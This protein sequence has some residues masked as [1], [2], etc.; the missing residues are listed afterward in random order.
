MK[1]QLLGQ[2]DVI[3]NGVTRPLGGPRQRAVLAALLLHANEEVRTTRLLELVWSDLPSSARSNLRTYLARLRRALRIPGEPE[4]RLQTRRCGHLVTVGPGE[5]DVATFL[6]FASLGERATDTVTAC[7][8]Y[9]R[10]LNA[11]RGRALE[12]VALGPL[13]EAEATQ[14]EAQRERVYERYLQVRLALGQ[15]AELLP[16]LRAQLLRNPLWEHLASMLMVALDRSGQRAEALNVFR[17]TRQRLVEEL[18]VEPG[19]EL[20]D[21][22]Q[23]LLADDDLAAVTERLAIAI[24]SAD[25][26]T[27]AVEKPTRATAK[28][29]LRRIRLR[30]RAETTDPVPPTPTDGE[31]STGP[32]QLPVDVPTFTGRAA[33]LAELAELTDGERR[34]S[35]PIIA[36]DGMAGVGKTTLAVHTAHL[37]APRFTDGQLFVNLHGCSS[38]DRPLD[39]DDVLDQML[40][41]F[42]VYTSPSTTTDLRASLF[43]SLLARRKIIVVLDN[44]FDEAQV[45]PLLPGAGS[46]QALVTSRRR[47]AGLHE[48]YSLSL[49]VLSSTDAVDLF[50]SICTAQRLA[51]QPL[52]LVEEI[53]ELCGL[54]PLAIRIAAMRL[55]IRPFWTLRDLRDRL[56]DEQQRLTELRAGE[57]DVESTVSLSLTGLDPLGQRVITMLGT[58]PGTRIELNAAAALAGLD[59]PAT[60]RVLE[61]LVDTHLLRQTGPTRYQMHSLVRATMIQR[62]RGEQPDEVDDAVR[63]LL[64]YY[65]HTADAADRQLQSMRDRPALCPADPAV[66]PLTFA[67]AEDALA[68]CDQFNPDFL[69]L[70]RAAVT[71][72]LFEHAWQLVVRMESY[73]DIRENWVGGMAVYELAL[74][75]A[76]QQAR[77]SVESELL[78]GLA[79][80][81][82]QLG[83]YDQAIAHYTTA[84]AVC[85]ETGSEYAEAFAA[86]ALARICR[87]L[88]RDGQAIGH[89]RR[90]LEIYRRLNDIP[91]VCVVLDDLG[92]TY[93][94]KGSLADAI[95]CYQEAFR[96]R[97]RVG[98]IQG[99]GR[100]LLKVGEA[101]CRAGHYAEA[102]KAARWAL[103]LCAQAGELDSESRT[104]L[105]QDVPAT[106]GLV[107]AHAYLARA[108]LMTDQ[109]AGGQTDDLA[110][111]LHLLDR[112]PVDQQ[113]PAAV[114]AQRA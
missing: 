75:A 13:L 90:A 66:T 9:E 53:V 26:A 58:H 82:A 74:Q 101:N 56:T 102:I 84:L 37:L 33:E 31:G 88:H 108:R 70:T 2:V 11:W 61:Q 68:W 86:M 15:H 17:Q 47:L 106:V 30:H 67:S 85:R 8:Y 97:W 43:R 52:E 111:Y 23:R 76:R 20:R 28:A 109:L 1:F 10:A 99:T 42:D 96:Y 91:A 18:G 34:D 83:R 110:T 46:S 71:R 19:G 5:L 16:E 112:P 29:G 39:P 49:D 24:V 14:L 107:Q 22:H 57:Q 64:D 87:R 94:E 69:P 98:D 21:L 45:H 60:E 7:R 92:D 113:D 65:T 44:A 100:Y 79:F 25:P 63:R 104:L 73:L 38:D 93:S 81:A 55:R 50:T 95:G 59:V 51:G 6:E 54:L 80:G 89:Q 114:S 72:G 35:R 40:R 4:S 78:I 36:L 12:N 48:A 27:T 105:A 32:A 41:T 77:R 3:Q 62:M 103:A